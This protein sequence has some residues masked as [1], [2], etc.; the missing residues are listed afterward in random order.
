MKNIIA[1]G[2]GVLISLVLASASA[3]ASFEESMARCISKHAN[4][5]DAA[6]VMLECSADGGKLSGCV[7]LQDS[8]AGKG[9]D[10][11][12]LCVADALPMGS[13]T[14]QVKVPMR[15]PGS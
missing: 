13:K 15:F 6:T 8:A 10:K 12:A 9:F 2:G 3:A 11:A 7:V 4:T 5:R 1:V 14:G